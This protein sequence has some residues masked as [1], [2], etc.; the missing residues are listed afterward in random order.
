MN[1]DEYD[2]NDYDDEGEL[3]FERGEDDSMDDD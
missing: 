1:S 2:I 3:I